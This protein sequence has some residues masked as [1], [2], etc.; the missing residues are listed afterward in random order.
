MSYTAS[1]AASSAVKLLKILSFPRDLDRKQERRE[2]ENPKSTVKLVMVQL[3]LPGRIQEQ[4]YVE[5]A[6]VVKLQADQGV[7]D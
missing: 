5:I 4:P 1:N 2:A 7:S 3:K 6:V